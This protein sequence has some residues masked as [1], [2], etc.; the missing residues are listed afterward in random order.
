MLRLDPKSR[1]TAEALLQEFRDEIMK[2]V[3][4]NTYKLKN[5]YTTATTSVGWKPTNAGATTKQI[6]SKRSRGSFVFARIVTARP[7]T[8]LR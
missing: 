8:A 5:K 2:F 3:S 6:R 4:S 7:T 1:P